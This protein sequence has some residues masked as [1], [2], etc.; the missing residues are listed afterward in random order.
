MEESHTKL[1]NQAETVAEV[2]QITE[3]AEL[4][5]MNEELNGGI[6]NEA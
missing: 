6:T 4:T 2:N 5:S 3:A 1:F